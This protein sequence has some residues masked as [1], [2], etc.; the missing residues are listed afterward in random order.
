MPKSLPAGFKTTVNKPAKFQTTVSIN[1]LKTAQ[2]AASGF[3]NPQ[4]GNRPNSR[5]HFLSA[6]FYVPERSCRV[7][8]IE[9]YQKKIHRRRIT[10]QC[11]FTK[12]IGLRNII[13]H[14]HLSINSWNV[15]NCYFVHIFMEGLCKYILSPA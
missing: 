7:R 11:F 12:L 13:R 1:H 8:K 15:W 2:I 10:R 6:S 9:K 14:F 3:L 5:L 4:C